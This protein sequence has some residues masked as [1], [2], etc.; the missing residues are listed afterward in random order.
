MAPSDSEG[1]KQVGKVSIFS[2]TFAEAAHSAHS[3][4]VHLGSVE[5][6]ARPELVEH[7]GLRRRGLLPGIRGKKVV[8]LQQD[9]RII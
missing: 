5:C 6:Y 4:G 3:L 2:C 7:T 8:D 1:L 9:E